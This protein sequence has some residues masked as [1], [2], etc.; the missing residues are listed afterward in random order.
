MQQR[1]L[2]KLSHMTGVDFNFVP[3]NKNQF[4]IKYYEHK[5]L[6]DDEYFKI[7]AL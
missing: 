7:A 3:A 1:Q 2:K 6:D 5:C 4:G